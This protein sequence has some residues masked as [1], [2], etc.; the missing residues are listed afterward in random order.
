MRYALLFHESAA[1]FA[2]REDPEKAGAYWAA[3]T[4]YI[5]A[6]GQSGI[7]LSGEGLLPP[8]TATTVRIRDGKRQIH[9]GPYAESKE[10]LGGFFVIEVPDLDVALEWAAR[11]PSSS[12]G[13]TEV[14]PLLPP[15]N[16]DRA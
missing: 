5:A 15:M 9:D 4:S 7:V 8:D 1:D 3:W 12:Y 14:R 6:L 13:S 10:M 16:S 2:L 11:A